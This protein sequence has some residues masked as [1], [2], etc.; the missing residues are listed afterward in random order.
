MT[1]T[2][3]TTT[4]LTEAMNVIDRALSSFTERELVSS[5][6]V[7]DILLD[8]RGMLAEHVPPTPEIEPPVPAG[9]GA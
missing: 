6:E 3:E 4:A 7:T 2:I 9:A 5:D 1:D 8:L